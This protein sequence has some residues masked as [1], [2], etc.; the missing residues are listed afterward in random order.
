MIGIAI[1]GFKPEL[2][3]GPFYSKKLDITEQLFI[4][5]SDD[6]KSIQTLNDVTKELV[7]FNVK[8]IP[9]KIKN[10]FDFYEVYFSVLH[11]IQ[12]NNIDWINVTAGPGISLV[13]ISTVLG[14]TKNLRYVYYHESKENIP[15]YTDVIN[16]NNIYIFTSRN[17]LF[18]PI[19]KILYNGNNSDHITDITEILGKS[20][21]TISR[22]L[23]ILLNMG[24]I[25]FS[26]TGHGN[27]KKKFKLTELGNRIYEYLEHK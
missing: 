9:V 14:K 7:K 17:N 11:L 26:G 3:I 5:Y 6:A 21:S 12:K 1:S 24:F 23:K 25:K 13:S 27:S 2:L 19:M 22:R 10:I 8:V 4:L 18:I 20:E 16:S 15:G